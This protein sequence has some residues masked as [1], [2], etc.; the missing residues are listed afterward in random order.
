MEEPTAET[1]E[2]PDHFGSE[3]SAP[4]DGAAKDLCKML[5]SWDP[6][7]AHELT[8]DH[9]LEQEEDSGDILRVWEPL[10]ESFHE[11]GSAATGNRKR[12]Y[13]ADVSADGRL[14]VMGFFSGQVH[15]TDERT[16]PAGADPHWLPVHQQPSKWAQA[17]C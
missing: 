4:P 3:D 7:K 8:H 9:R 15:I 13:C 14:G 10:L 1:P 5:Q 11:V 6:Q 16:S 17:Y 2:P 12:A